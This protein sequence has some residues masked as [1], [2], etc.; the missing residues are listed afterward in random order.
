LRLSKNRRRQQTEDAK[1]KDRERKKTEEAKQNARERN[2]TEEAKQKAKERKK[3]EEA[4]SLRRK[5]ERVG[6]K[7]KSFKSA[8]TQPNTVNPATKLLLPSM[9][10]EC[11]DCG[12]SMFPW[13]VS[14]TKNEGT[15]FS[16]C[17][18]Y[19][20]IKL[21]PFKDPSPKLK[22]LFLKYDS[23][24]KQFLNNIR[25]YNGLVSMAS[26]GIRGGK[27]EDYKKCKS[28]GP[29]PFKLS[30]QL[31]HRIPSV[32][33]PEGDK[34]PK[35]SQ[36]YVYDLKNEL[37]NRIL[38]AKEKKYDDKINQ[39]TLKLIQEDLKENNHYVKQFKSAG[40]IFN[41]NPN[42]D[43]KL[44]YFN[45]LFLVGM[46]TFVPK[47]YN[48]SFFC[49]ITRSNNTNIINNRVFMFLFGSS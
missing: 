17:C 36:I 41:A 24:S 6:K 20:T 11:C 38:D 39:T 43:M 27:L 35:F 1:Q 19:G 13:E 49:L 18:S 29:T 47:K 48:I 25:I 34:P 23:Q 5:R 45:N 16:K 46:A 12:A 28:R 3:T 15:S 14:K 2:K 42:K 8:W 33:F 32:L 30:G 37:D 21:H 31:Y 26:K 40:E 4:K 44:V 10:S 9:T 22:E 7:E